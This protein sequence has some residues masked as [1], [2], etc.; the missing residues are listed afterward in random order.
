MTLVERLL[1]EREDRLR[2]E[3]ETTIEQVLLES[4]MIE[5]IFQEP[6]NKDGSTK[7]KKQT[8]E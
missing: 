4:K 8:P 1:K 6:E 3:E 2:E 7:P 5:N